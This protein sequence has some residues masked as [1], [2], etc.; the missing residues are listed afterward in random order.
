MRF[1]FDPRFLKHGTR[2]S[3]Y[4]TDSWDGYP[5]E[6]NEIMDF[7][8]ESKQ[9]N[10]V[11]MT[12]D[13]HAHFAGMVLDDYENKEPVAVIPELVGSGI[14][15]DDRF[16]IQMRL[17]KDVELLKRTGFDGKKINYY[18]KD[19]PALNAWMLY[20]EQAAAMLSKTADTE[21]A[22]SVADP[23]INSHLV[24]ADTDAYGYYSVRVRKDRIY[25]EF[26]T[27]PIPLEDESSNT[28]KVRRRVRMEI[29][30]WQ[31]GTAPEINNISFDGEETILGIKS[32]T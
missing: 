9:T 18:T 2:S 17:F 27:I 28:P 11:S 3:I 19:A 32:N 31:P 26:V 20:G 30:A 7:L 16:R 14:S 25:T 24:Y 10:I 15:A 6:R 23:S 21:R 5:I 8:K 4:W 13:R 12:G 22:M 29:P 1:G